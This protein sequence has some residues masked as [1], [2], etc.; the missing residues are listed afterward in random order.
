MGYEVDFLPV[1]EESKSGD[2]IAIR[3]GD[4]YG[5]RDDYKVVVID[6][7]FKESGEKLVEHVKKYYNTDVV[8]LAILTHPDADHASGLEVVLN[9]LTVKQL[10]MHLPWNHTED[11]ANMFKDGRVTDQS[12]KESLRR[13]LENARSLENLA[14]SKDIPI[15]EPFTG[16]QDETGTIIVAGPSEEY[17]ESLLPEFKGTPES[18]EGGFFEKA[19][20]AVL[21][22]ARKIAETF[23]H[24]TLDNN[25]ETTA[26]N[27][28]SVVLRLKTENN[29]VLFTGDA[30]IPALTLAADYLEEVGT[31]HSTID[32]IQVPHHGS[33]R[34]VGPDILNRLVGPKLNED[35]QLKLA[36]ASV[37]QKG[38][39]KH[40]A[41]K[42]TNAFRRR[43]AYVHTTKG[44]TKHYFNNA[45]DRGWSASVPLP[46][47]PEVE[48]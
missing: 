35:K 47:Y 20:E 34:N 29:D 37:A 22:V 45:P 13:S 36:L 6:G 18:K 27:N 46:F 39:P 15:A 11:I 16:L 7:G 4:L 30:G 48:E 19:L 1:G 41:K 28:S 10:W 8:D 33:K 14:K 12:V 3:F 38:E 25:G 9:E 32:L 31:D 24:E 17:Y 43:G 5:T 2:A 42:V 21:E 26:E 40:P 23:N 44:G